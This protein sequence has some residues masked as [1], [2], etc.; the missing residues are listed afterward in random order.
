MD[1]WIFTQFGNSLLGFTSIGIAALG[2]VWPVGGASTPPAPTEGEWRLLEPVS[3]ENLTV[4]PVVSSSG[5][6]TSA[7][8][9][10]EEGLSRGEVVVREQGAEVLV[11]NRGERDSTVRNYGGPSVNQLVL[12]NHSKRPLLLLA[13][14]LVS[15]GKQDRI[16]AKD[17][18]VAPGSEPLPLDVF[19]VE[20][21]R[22]SS[23]SQFNQAKI[24]VHPSVR[25]Q[26]AVTKSQK[27]VWSSVAGGTVASSPAPGRPMTAAEAPRV[28][29]DAL[30]GVMSSDA[31]TQSY[32][33]IYESKY[34]GTSVDTLVEEIQRRFQRETRG[35]K[36][37]RVVGVV[38]AYGG[39]VAWSDIF[40]SSELFDAY[41][42]KLIRSYAVE[43]VARLT[44][45]EKASVEDARE[46]LIRVG[47]NE[48]TESEP[49]VYRWRET[50]RG[51]LSQIELEALEP[52]VITV[53]R[54]VLRRTS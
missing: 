46:F 15:G 42:G 23:G 19:C 13:G 50:K 40:A 47:G 12:I 39:E 48:Q 9:T 6:D 29:A 1:R 22:W 43:A 44:L 27:E 4:F 26:A 28:S 35:L 3:Y 53:H 7:F 33:K 16:I 45:R 49:G 2:F 52:K 10:L 25:E 24:I 34:V 20:H 37:E 38:V 17:R 41:W 21:G 36:G 31:P 51:R 18:I 32:A 30:R 8:L 54:L 5:Y 14:E 11:R